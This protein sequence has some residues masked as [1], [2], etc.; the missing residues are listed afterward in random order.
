MY[1][2]LFF[3]ACQRTF[4]GY[5]GVLFVLIIGDKI[6]VNFKEWS[7]KVKEKKWDYFKPT[8]ASLERPF[9]I[10]VIYFALCFWW[11]TYARVGVEVEKTKIVQ[12]EVRKLKKKNKNLAD[13]LKRALEKNQQSIRV[14]QAGYP[15]KQ[16]VLNLAREIM[17]FNRENRTSDTF[18]DDYYDQ[19]LDP[20]N[21]VLGD[22]MK[23]G[24]NVKKEKDFCASVNSRIELLKCWGK[25][26]EIAKVLQQ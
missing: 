4:Y 18:A 1:K 14:I 23:Q 10:A 8:L 9:K 11:S 12:E 2:E 26:D 17:N 22:V 24:I 5:G 19:F 21:L 7:E 20:I 15:L 13:D 16:R 6:I 3:D 25:L